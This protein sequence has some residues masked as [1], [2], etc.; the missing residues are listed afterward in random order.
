MKKLSILIITILCALILSGCQE[1]LR[2]APSEPMKQG[3]EL[4]HELAKKIN[5]EGT[6]PN[7][8]ASQKMV[9][10]TQIALSYMGR[11][12]V[13]PDPE[14]FDTI[15]SLAQIDAE[16]RPDPWDVADSMLE[17]GIGICALF[18]GVYG[19]KAVGLLKQAKTKSKALKEIIAGNEV[20][21]KQNASTA[22]A[23][24]QAH[25]SQSKETRKIVAEMKA[26]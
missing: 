14:Q 1:P 24:K 7:S 4:T 21:K 11:P 15:T 23:F 8:Q 19:T 6:E 16:K 2:F 3:A 20:F 18:G 26:A 22:T 13:P 5:N 25:Q 12:K 17:L 10:G 9:Q